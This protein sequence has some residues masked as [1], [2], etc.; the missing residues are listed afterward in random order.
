MY[1][2]TKLLEASPQNRPILNSSV[3]RALENQSHNNIFTQVQEHQ[4][5]HDEFIHEH[6]FVVGNTLVHI[7]IYLNYIYDNLFPNK[8]VTLYS[9]YSALYV[10]KRLCKI[11]NLIT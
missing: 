8:N 7:K 4:N 2:I 9:C 6:K 1:Y 3:E 11:N 5:S 10:N